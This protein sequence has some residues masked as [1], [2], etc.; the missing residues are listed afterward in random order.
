MRLSEFRDEQA[1][2]VVARL[3]GPMSNIAANA[4][5]AEARSRGAAQFAAA[6]LKNCP[7]DVM[8]ILAI[9]SGKEP[10]AYHCTAASVLADVLDM[11]SDPELTRLFGLQ[12]KTEASSGSASESI[13]APGA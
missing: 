9:L 5:N 4:Q 3:M 13:E 1:I 12:S 2:E 6:L 11:L 8:D 10:E 7:R